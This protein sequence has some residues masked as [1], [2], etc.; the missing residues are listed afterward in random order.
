MLIAVI[1]Y[2]DTV[3]HVI[4][5]VICYRPPYEGLMFND[6]KEKFTNKKARSSA[7]HYANEQ[8]PLPSLLVII[9]ILL[10]LSGIL[11]PSFMHLK[12]SYLNYSGEF[13]NNPNGHPSQL[14]L[15]FENDFNIRRIFLFEFWVL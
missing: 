1:D 11:K 14:N 15:F 3:C 12:T 8:T 7:V 4:E 10:T 2:G 9:N 13:L 6:S 5:M